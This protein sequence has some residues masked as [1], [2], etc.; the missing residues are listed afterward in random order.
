MLDEQGIK[1][2]LPEAAWLAFGELQKEL[3]EWQLLGPTSN[4]KGFTCYSTGV[5]VINVSSLP[6]HS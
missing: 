3:L 2:Y 5:A 6:F 1:E 4:N